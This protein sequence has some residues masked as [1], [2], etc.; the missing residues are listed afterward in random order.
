MNRI[1]CVMLFC[2]AA[3]Q[4]FAQLPSCNGVRYRNYAFTGVDSTMNVQYGQNV[5]ANNVTQNLIMDIY[6][7]HGDTVM[8]RPL[9]IFIHGGAFV[10]GNRTEGTGFCGLMALEG[11]VAATI[12][13]RLID[14]P[15][16]DSLT[17]TDGMIKAISDAKAAI[18]YFVEDAATANAYKIDT[19]YIFIAGGSAGAI[20]AVATTYLNPADNIPTYVLNAINNNGGFSGNSSTNT[21]YG[22]PIKGVLSYSGAILYKDWISA[23]EPPMLSVHDI[24]DTIVPCGYDD[25]K[26]F[27]F[28]MYMYGTCE[29][30]GEANLKGVYNDT[31]IFA[32]SGHGAYFQN[33]QALLD[34]LQRTNNFLYTLICT[35][36][37]SINDISDVGKVTIYPNPVNDQ[38]QISNPENV[39][40]KNV[41]IYSINGA[42]MSVHSSSIIA[43]NNLPSGLYFLTIET[44][45]GTTMRKLVKE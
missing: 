14:V 17:V 29:M 21:N 26:A 12:D 20:T 8:R 7:P 2:M 23:G 32:G 18:R 33:N 25:S 38:L 45:M 19:N 22:T 30:K 15:V 13:Y 4:A 24:G 44:D 5:T 1:I 11:Y 43:T 42:L 27:A 10:G 34:V 28:S 6:Q 16:H 31:M 9:I 3:S 36:T 41:K 35:N 39:A 37:V 40:I